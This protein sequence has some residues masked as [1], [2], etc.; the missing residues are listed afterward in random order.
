MVGSVGVSTYSYL[1]G[2]PYHA[3]NPDPLAMVTEKLPAAVKHRE[4]LL[5]P[6]ESPED[7]IKEMDNIL[8]MIG[9]VGG[10]NIAAIN[11]FTNLAK[12]AVG[13]YKKATEE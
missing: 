5:H 6:L 4:D 7:F 8:K 1:T 12:P 11:A 13:V 9:L 2:R 3:R 10:P